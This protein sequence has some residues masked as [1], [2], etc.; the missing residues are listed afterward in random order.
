MIGVYRLD[1]FSVLADLGSCSVEVI[2]IW[3][4][5]SAVDLSDPE[6]PRLRREAGFWS[7]CLP[8]DYEIQLGVSLSERHLLLNR[9]WHRVTDDAPCVKDGNNTDTPMS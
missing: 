8:P 6:T 2:H 5:G 4:Q 1:C 7:T 3:D 9:Q